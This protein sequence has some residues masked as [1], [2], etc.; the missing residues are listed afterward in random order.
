MDKPIR[1][2]STNSRLKLVRKL[3]ESSNLSS[4]NKSINDNSLST[5]NKSSERLT[6][7]RLP[8]IPTS[9]SKSSGI[10]SSESTSLEITE[11]SI[12]DIR[13]ALKHEWQVKNI[14]KDLQEIF[15]Q[16]VWTLPRHKAISIAS[17]ELE[18]LKN[19]RSSMQAALRAVNAREDSLASI[20]EMN[21]YLK[22]VTGW[23]KMRDVQLE[24]AELLH[25]HRIL[26]INAVESIVK[27]KELISFSALINNE[28]NSMYIPFIFQGKN[29]LLKLRNDL[30][31]LKDSEFS[32]VF[33]FENND[34]LLI[35]P[36]KPINK[37][38]DKK[39]DSNYFIQHG[40]VVVSLPSSL[41]P[42]ADY[43]EDIL[44]REHKIDNM[45]TP[46][47]IEEMSNVIYEEMYEEE[48]T[49]HVDNL[50][51]NTRPQVIDGVFDKIMDEML[52][53]MCKD[54]IKENK[55]QK[56]K[57]NDD[58]I[59]PEIVESFVNREVD[60][61]LQEIVKEQAKML[62]KEKKD[63]QIREQRVKEENLNIARMIYNELFNDLV[64]IMS[65]QTLSE[66]NTQ[67]KEADKK[68]FEIRKAKENAEIAERIKNDYLEEILKSLI[69]EIAKTTYINEQ[70]TKIT[71]QLYLEL[72]N[73]LINQ[74][75]LDELNAI[76]K[77]ESDKKSAFKNDLSSLILNSLIDSLIPEFTELAKETF[78]EEHKIYQDG[79][80][81]VENIGFEIGDH[82]I[83][84]DFSGLI[85]QKIP[86]PES[87]INKVVEDYYPR[88]PQQEKNVT[89]EEEKLEQDTNQVEAYWYWGLI[90][91]IV[92]G[93]LV[94][95]I[96][97]DRNDV[98]VI[99]VHHLTCLDWKFYP[100]IID[101]ACK[102]LWKHD[103]CQEIRVNLYVS[104]PTEIPLDVKKVFN[105]QKFRWKTNIVDE[106]EEC[107]IIVMGKERPVI[108][109]KET[110][111][112]KKRAL[113]PSKAY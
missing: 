108:K 93:L 36:S 90:R 66:I 5:L 11:E 7:F 111:S 70:N 113:L 42:K 64:E 91:N 57:G 4:I 17:R 102:F 15:D 63:N 82:S 27:W 107:S 112:P 50:V 106:E 38:K 3:D 74:N 24:C 13:S 94:F 76:K 34:P 44:G 43:V 26:T 30:D 41:K 105:A 62:E 86:L 46:V 29:Y 53:E 69:P 84:N 35:K 10:K 61:Q 45:M 22:E 67:H 80:E 100:N 104:G 6:K 31:F 39:I 56:I 88:I 21:K 49:N 65:E 59:V 55:M 19:N 72:L 95:S 28:T 75:A 68:M 52:L 78:E 25:A 54:V 110:P 87:V 79:S 32:K 60:R 1:S 99:N 37:L 51:N 89:A 96:D 98:R 58:K 101:A 2:T 18:D 8:R 71:E 97:F 77:A 9:S 109:I 103:H 40:Q 47:Q 16:K 20:Y 48:I 73:S 33:A 83:F 12:S 23:E 81:L 14:P 92:V 85:F